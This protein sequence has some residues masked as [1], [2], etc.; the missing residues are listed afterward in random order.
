MILEVVGIKTNS[1]L[2]QV[3]VP[4]VAIFPVLIVAIIVPLAF[5]ILKIR[6]G[7]FPAEPSILET[8]ADNL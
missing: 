7:K 3:K 6:L 1:Y 8:Q 2:F 5:L 4:V